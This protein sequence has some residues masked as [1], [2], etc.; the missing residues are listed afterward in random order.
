MTYEKWGR[1]VEG[2]SVRFWSGTMVM[3]FLGLLILLTFFRFRLVKHYY[4]PNGN[5][6]HS[7][8]RSQHFISPFFYVSSTKLVLVQCTHL[9][10]TLWSIIGAANI[11][12]PYLFIKLTRL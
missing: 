2:G 12:A 9:N 7:A 1:L 10:C 11:T 4:C 3:G 8:N 6:I 5:A